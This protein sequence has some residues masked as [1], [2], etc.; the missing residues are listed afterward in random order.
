[1][2]SSALTDSPG[3]ITATP[4]KCRV[5]GATTRLGN[6]LCL[7]CTLLEALNEDYEGS[8]ESFE[9]ALVQSEVKD[10]HWR[11]DNYEVL[12]E[13]GRGGMGVIYRARQRHS[14]RIVALKRM[15]SYHADSRET[16]ERFRREAE[17]A[18]SLDHP[19]ILPVYEV[20]QGEDGLP[21]FSMKYAAGGSLQKAA[22]AMRS[23]QRESVRLITKVARAVQY[24]HEHG[25]VHRD[26]KPGNILLDAHGEPFVTDFGLAKWLDTNTDLT[27]TLAIFGTPGYIAPEQARGSTTP[28]ADI[29]SLGAILFNLFTGRPPFLGEHALAVIEQANEKPAPKLRLLVPSLDRDLETIVARCL[30]REPKGRYQSA[31]AL[32]DDL[33]RWLRHEPIRARRSGVYT[34]GRKWVR[35]NPTTTVLIAALVVLAAAIVGVMVWKNESP[36]PIPSLPAGIAVLPLQNLSEEKENAYF[37]DGIQDELLTNLSKIRD[38]KVISRTSVMQ[39]K[40]GITR[41]LKE[42]AQQLGVSNVVEGSVRRSGNHVRVSVQLIDAKTNRHL[43]AQNY[44]RTLADSV[45]LQGDLATEIAAALGGTLSPQEKAR[46]QAKPTKNTAAYDAYLRG[47]AFAARSYQKSYEDNAIQSYQEAVRL[48]PGFALAWARLSIAVGHN[49]WDPSPAQ[50]AAVK[51]TADHALSLDPDLPETHLAVGYYRYGQHD[52]TGA[53]AEFQQAEQGLPNNAEVIEAIAL[54][55]RR[56]GHWE[57]ALTGLRR[58]I[59]LDPRYHDA[60]ENLAGTYRW[61]RRFPE[62]LATVDQLLAWEPNDVIAL[63][64][65]AAALWAMGDLQA[66]EPLLTNLGFDSYDRGVQALFQRRYAAAIEIFSAPPPSN[67]APSPSTSERQLFLG[68][69]QQ[70]AGDVAAARV[71]YQKAV[72]DF[73]RDLEKVV[74]G[75][76]AE[77]WLRTC[78]GRA[79]AGL[80]EAASAIAEG[81]KAMAIDPTS[82][83]PVDGP[84]REEK[85]ANIYA[86]LGDADHAIPIL[87]RL[88]QTTYAG[89]ITP[90]LLRL[91]PIWDQIR[92]DPRFRELAEEGKSIPEKSIAV[93]PFENLSADPESA[94]FADGVQ[95]EILNDLAKIADLKVI[96]RTSV[97]QYKTGAKRNLRQ[98]ASELGVAHVVEGSVQR[99]ANHVRVSA[100]LI[101]AKTDTHLW[102]ERYDRPVNDVFAIQSEIAK[103]V[104]S[105][106]QAK[107]SPRE[108]NAV[109]AAPTSDPEAYDLFL[110]GEYEERQAEGAENVELFDRAEAFY[111]QALT[112]DPNFALAYARLAYSRLNRHWFINRLSSAQLEEVKSNIDRALA[113]APESPEAYLAL[114]QYHYWGHRDYDSALRALHRAIELQPSNSDSRISRGAIYR[115]RGEWRRALAEFERALELNPR[116]PSSF[117]ELGNAYG[118]LRRWSEAERMYARA[119]A[120][121]PH[122]INAAFHLSV[123][124]I[125]GT[126]D[127]RRARGAQEAAPEQP[128]G[129]VSPYGVVIS[130]M[131]NEKV[132]LDVLER[133]FAD[134]LKAWD[135]LPSNTAEERLNKLKAR[136]GIQLLAGQKAVARSAAEQARNLLEAQLAERA[137]EDRT[138]LTEVAWIYVCLG[139]N[140]DALRIAQE[141]TESLPIEEDAIFGG[142]FLVGLAQIDAHIGR[143][144]EA[145]KILRQLLTVPAGEYISLTRLKID[146]VW[147]PIRNDPGF[148]KLLSE[149]EPETVYK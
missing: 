85:M 139:R 143:P 146:P 58:T 36:H 81:E 52:Y 123:T 97:M 46:V 124:Y 117:T 86:L 148:Q 12:E 55:Q 74:P 34:R 79:Y 145:V 6:G 120:L 122:N 106:L 57:E 90:A 1:M 84:V 29:Y 104:A 119:L 75:S 37:A 4:A 109:A 126:G 28:T 102:A 95:D 2:Q 3:G 51:D 113:I 118:S 54:V 49:G 45:A 33:E 89:A 100:Q 31:G 141:A 87:K 69:S 25:I 24:A 23:E 27:R 101:D 71:T 9:A 94:F 14:R 91:D 66:V 44:D 70:R 142:N 88:L 50:L 99:V 20:G 128:K 107:L 115:R 127:I 17:A 26:L 92:N 41:N 38:L 22:P 93:L 138:S 8:R 82:R 30:E 65:K 116:D 98:I 19:N 136:V 114:G 10:T 62:T 63:G 133:H 80:G 112:R 144:E 67:L 60:Y 7:S 130:Q 137:P 111:R 140:D 42:I 11:V 108:A 43:W 134:A 18:A 21:F 83:N 77:A 15:V 147:D 56:L 53:L 125:N 35:R 40:S 135:V 105:Q 48:D 47:R 78:V 73:Q 59:E 76:W 64:R 72:H 103:A 61:L 132:Y 32:A 110:K 5:C 39:Y 13:I 121:D 96:S 68:L 16:R 129:Q 149:P 131:I